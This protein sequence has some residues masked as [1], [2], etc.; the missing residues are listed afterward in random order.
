MQVSWNMGYPAIVSSLLPINKDVHIT[1]LFMVFCV[2]KF[3]ILMTV[4]TTVTQSWM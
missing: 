4:N 1:P 2:M 3:E